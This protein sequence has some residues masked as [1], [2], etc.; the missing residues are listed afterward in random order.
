MGRGPKNVFRCAVAVLLVAAWSAAAARAQT[1]TSRPSDFL[2]MSLEDLMNVQVTSVSKHKQKVSEAPAA[3][4]VITADD[5]ERSGLQS[6]PELLRLAPGLD[7]ARIDSSQ[8]AI[9]SRGFNDLFGNKLLV[10]MDGRTLYTPL[11]SGVFWD[12]QDYVLPDLDRIEVIRGPGATLWGSNAVNGVINIE[13]KSSRETQGLFVQ[14][15]GGNE[16]D[17]AT[18]RYGGKIDNDTYFR[19]FAKGRNF[20][21]FPLATGGEAHDDWQSG[22]GGLRIDRYSTDKDL[23]TFETSAY[24]SHNDEA[25]TIPALAAPT[26]HAIDYS[27]F[28]ANE[29][30][31]LG[32]W[33]HTISATSDLALQMYY[34]HLG[35]RVWQDNGYELNTLDIDFHH[36]FELAKQHE[37]TWGLGCRFTA[38]DATATELSP[39]APSYLTPSRRDDYFFSGFVQDDIALVADRLHAIVGTK[40]EQNSYSGFEVEPS[41]KLLWTPNDTNSLWGSISR[42]VRTPSRWEEDSTLTAL[43][44]PTGTPYPGLIQSHGNPNFLAENLLAYEVGYRIKP[45]PRISADVSAFFNQYTSLQGFDTGNAT[46]VGGSSPHLVIPEQLSND[47]H[48]D[49]FGVELAATWRVTDAWRLTG[50][51]TFQQAHVTSSQP[52]LLGQA[53]YDNGASPHN[54]FQIHSYLDVTKNVQLNASGYFVEALAGGVPS[55]FRADLGAVWRIRDGLEL[56]AGVQNMFDNQHSEFAGFRVINVESQ[57]PRTFYGTLTWHF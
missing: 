8:W 54:Q 42:A 9:S 29:Q 1:P 51:Y 44:V 4:T 17:S 11:F 5:I 39:A 57:V 2:D 27:D 22:M 32:R 36:R 35:R 15:L 46:I 49:T 52:D 3:I 47:L 14:G 55:Y 31:L 19:V 28:Y 18:V 34:D 48:G 43:S 12:M 20:E 37:V 53:A 45:H 10:M 16:Q 30:Y 23:L 21:S 40:L 38:D 6:I 50:S 26:L 7:V 41:G 25:L 24:T 56:A 13:S 33:T